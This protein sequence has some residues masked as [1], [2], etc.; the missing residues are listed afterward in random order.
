[1]RLRPTKRQLVIAAALLL[2]AFGC[3]MMVIVFR[4]LV[5]VKVS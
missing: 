2:L 1:M 4:A 5:G 3:W